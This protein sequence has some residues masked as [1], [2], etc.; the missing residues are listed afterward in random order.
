MAPAANVKVI[1]LTFACLSLRWPP[2]IDPEAAASRSARPLGH[3]F[4]LGDRYLKRYVGVCESSG[5]T[6][7]GDL[8]PDVGTCTAAV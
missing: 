8:E 2:K 6:V 1:A 5:R 7:E 3:R 4:E